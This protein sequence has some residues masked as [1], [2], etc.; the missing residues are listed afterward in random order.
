MVLIFWDDSWSYC[1]LG[2]EEWTIA[3]IEDYR[4]SLSPECVTETTVS[5]IEQRHWNDKGDLRGLVYQKQG[6]H[7]NLERKRTPVMQSGK[8][9]HSTSEWGNLASRGL[10]VRDSKDGGRYS[11]HVPQR[12]LWA[13]KRVVAPESHLA[14]SGTHQ[15]NGFSLNARNIALCP[16][17]SSLWSPVPT[18]PTP[19]SASRNQP[20]ARLCH[21][22]P[23]LSWNDR[24]PHIWGAASPH[25]L[26][27]WSLYFTTI[28]PSLYQETRSTS[29][30]G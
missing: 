28:N 7:I 3:T 11:Q 4:K 9:R 14:N 15:F 18:S 2:A 25:M 5:V 22:G 21:G 24:A 16:E 20:G 19:V 6:F 1:T 23:G 27:P 26:L 8:S 12:C 17:A 10:E 29:Y 13:G 30:D